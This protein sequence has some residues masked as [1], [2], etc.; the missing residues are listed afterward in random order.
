M[1]KHSQHSGEELNTFPLK[2]GTRGCPL[3]PLLVNTVS[4]VLA[5]TIRQEI[6]GI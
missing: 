3:S 1:T 4:E 6:K 5:T 2:Y